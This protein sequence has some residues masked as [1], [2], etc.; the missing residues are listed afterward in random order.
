MSGTEG[1]VAQSSQ[2]LMTEVS[3]NVSRD[4]T[5]IYVFIRATVKV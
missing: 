4:G 3:D 5:A 2:R 1:V